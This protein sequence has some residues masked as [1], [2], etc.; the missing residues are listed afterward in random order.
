MYGPDSYSYDPVVNWERFSE[1][2]QAALAHHFTLDLELD[3]WEVR[4]VPAPCTRTSHAPH[5]VLCTL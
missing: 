1:A 4:R 3:R 2:E 5:M